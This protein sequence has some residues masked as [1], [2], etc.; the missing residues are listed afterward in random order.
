MRTI[1]WIT[2]GVLVVLCVIGLVTYSQ[3]KETQQAVAG[4]ITR[5]R[6]ARYGEAG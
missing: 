3:E 2:G 1:Y 6:A 5:L 4:T